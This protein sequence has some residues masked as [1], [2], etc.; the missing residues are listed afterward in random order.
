MSRAQWYTRPFPLFVT[1]VFVAAIGLVVVNPFMANDRLFGRDPMHTVAFF[2]PALATVA[3]LHLAVPREE[4]ASVL[5]YCLRVFG[6]CLLAYATAAVMLL[7]AIFA[8]TG[9]LI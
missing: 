5:R 1:A 8:L 2:L 9:E 7:V 3:F 4:R 6:V